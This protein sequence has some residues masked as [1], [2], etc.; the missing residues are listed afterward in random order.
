MDTLN[1]S[2]KTRISHPVSIGDNVVYFGHFIII[3]N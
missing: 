1:I 2:I 3:E